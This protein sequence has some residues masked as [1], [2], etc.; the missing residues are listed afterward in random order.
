M[1][2]KPRR[3]GK[4]GFRRASRGRQG[5]STANDGWR[6]R[7][8]GDGAGPYPADL[9]RLTY[10]PPSTTKLSVYAGLA[11]VGYLALVVATFL[12]WISGQDGSMTGLGGLSGVLTGDNSS[13]LGMTDGWW[14]LIIGLA[15]L[16]ATLFALGS[17]PESGRKRAKGMIVGGLLAFGWLVIDL[18]RVMG[19][20]SNLSSYDGSE[21]VGA[22]LF[23]ALLAAVAVVGSVLLHRALGD[24]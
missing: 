7:R 2:V 14:M 6:G 12:P 11:A 9:P 1:C 23:V 22:G 10:K 3:R 24:Y 20:Q 18:F 4:I 5:N 21:G 19:A 13:S 17:N 8:R 15:A 16:V